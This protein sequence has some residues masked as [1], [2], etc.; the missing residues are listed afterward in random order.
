MLLYLRIFAVNPSMRYLIWGGIGLQVI[1]YT[2][3]TAI[4]I[5]LELVC[6]ADSAL[7]N[8]FCA[9]QYKNTV[10]QAVFS[11]ATDLYVL[12][13]PIKPLLNLQLSSRRRTGV[14]ILFA[15]GLL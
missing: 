5:S 13:L 11:F 6:A 15:T 1:V 8:S 10:F 2:A 3:T 7:T 14:M 9:N 12:V 4:A